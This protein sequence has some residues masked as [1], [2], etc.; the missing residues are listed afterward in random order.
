M[1][2]SGESEETKMGKDD[3]LREEGH[4]NRPGSRERHSEDPA[5][6]T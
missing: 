2:E 6:W 3:S 1:R 5:A 4:R